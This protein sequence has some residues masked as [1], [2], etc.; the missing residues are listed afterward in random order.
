VVDGDVRP[1]TGDHGEYHPVAGQHVHRQRR[2]APR[3]GPGDQRAH[4]R[5]SYA[6]ALPGVG[7][8]HADVAHAGAAGIPVILG[9]VRGH[10]VPDDDAVRD[11]DYGVDVG[12]PAGQQ[13]EQAVGGRDRREEPE[14]AALD[15]QP[16]E[17][18]TERG[19][20]LRAHRT[21]RGGGAAIGSRRL[22]SVHELS[23]AGIAESVN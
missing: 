9:T 16:R 1:V 15:G 14:I 20:V 13:V 8:H 6:P 3:L 21:D 7:D 11:G 10:R 22:G 4:Q 17:E 23:M 19:Q 12:G 18:V 2:H 5:R